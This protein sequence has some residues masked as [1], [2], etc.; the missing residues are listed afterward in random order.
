MALRLRHVPSGKYLSVDSTR[1]AVSFRPAPSV[2]RGPAVGTGSGGSGSAGDG[3]PEDALSPLKDEVGGSEA[4]AAAAEGGFGAA[5]GRLFDC[6]L[7]HD[8]DPSAA[9]GALGS[10][11]SMLFHLMPT[12]V[13]GETLRRG[14]RGGCLPRLVSPPFTSSSTPPPRFF[15]IPLASALRPSFADLIY[16]AL[17][18]GGHVSAK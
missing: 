14:V 17:I 11:A 6:A 3:P 10:A 9:P 5:L 2:G 18:D 13:T 4:A 7:V 15:S 16:N 12:D 1:T 8:A